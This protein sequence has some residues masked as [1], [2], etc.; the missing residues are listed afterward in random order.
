MRSLQESFRIRLKI[1]NQRAGER[2][3]DLD[4]HLGLF[5]ALYDP[6]P[7]SRSICQGLALRNG[8]EDGVF[9]PELL[10]QGGFLRRKFSIKRVN[11]AGMTKRDAKG[12]LQLALNL[13][14]R[15]KPTGVDVAGFDEQHELISDDSIA[16]PAFGSQ[17]TDIAKPFIFGQPVP[18]GV[19]AGKLLDDERFIEV[20]ARLSR[21][22]RSELAVYINPGVPRTP[23]PQAADIGDDSAFLLDRKSVV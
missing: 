5:F 9:P 19:D 8:R 1:T 16:R 6:L 13:P 14:G 11:D 17:I 18:E 4:A 20:H 3:S 7:E 21:I 12:L 23:V 22:L 15:S 10:E 2:V